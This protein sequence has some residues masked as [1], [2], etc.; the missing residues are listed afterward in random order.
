MKLF[1][2]GRAPN[3]RRVRVFLA[4]K[5][6]EV[7]LVPIDM[8]ALEHKTQAVSSRNPLQRLPV[9]ELDDGTIITESVAICRYF[10]ELYPEPPLFGQGALGKARV[11]MWQRRM[12]LNLLSCVAQAFRHTHPAMKEWEIP[13]IPEWGEA[14]KPKAVEFLKLLDDELAGREFAAGDAYSIADITGLIAI[15]FM[16]P[17]RI[18]VPEE[19]TNVLRWHAAISSR[20]SAAA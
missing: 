1:D 14:N 7:P 5:G 10:E 4:E 11:E 15:D 6:I 20:P 3:P 12:E 9:I 8:G 13:Q 19:C 2:G 17:A 16:K 18:R